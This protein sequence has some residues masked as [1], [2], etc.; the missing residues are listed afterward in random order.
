M[1]ESDASIDV[2]LGESATFL[3]MSTTDVGK[4]HRQCIRLIDRPVV[5][6]GPGI[7]ASCVIL[8]KSEIVSGAGDYAYDWL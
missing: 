6:L 2:Q 7:Y 8:S 1:N 5:E 3:S 4:R